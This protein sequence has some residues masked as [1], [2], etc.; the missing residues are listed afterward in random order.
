MGLP[1]RANADGVLLAVR[2]TPRASKE[3]VE[4]V[5]HDADGAAWLAVKVRAAPD[6]GQANK[7]VIALISKTLGTPKSA[8]T[9]E[10][11]AAARLKRISI[12]CN[13]YEIEARLRSLAGD[14][15]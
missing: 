10:S 8:L 6:D 13:T 4:G 3:A 9:L 11:G 1:W 12:V 7:A 15:T 14:E 2:V 5:W